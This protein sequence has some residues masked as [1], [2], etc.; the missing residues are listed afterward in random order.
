MPAKGLPF[1]NRDL[2]SSCLDILLK[3]GNI[4]LK[5]SFLLLSLFQAGRMREGSKEYS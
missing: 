5:L 3:I 4:T 2:E 1:L